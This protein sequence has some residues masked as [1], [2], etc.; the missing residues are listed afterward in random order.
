MDIQ[1]LL[2]RLASLWEEYAD[3][4]DE[5]ASIIDSDATSQIQ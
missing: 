3:I 5:K 2:L 1:Q 4:C